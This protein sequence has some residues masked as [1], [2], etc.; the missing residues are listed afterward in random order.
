[1]EKD[2][3]Y[4]PNDIHQPNNVQ[5]NAE[6]FT[7]IQ[8]KIRKAGTD[9]PH[10]VAD[11]YGILWIPLKGTITGYA[12]SYSVVNAIGINERL[13]G[14]WLKFAAWHELTHIFAGHVRSGALP[15]NGYFRQEVDSLAI[16]RHERCAN[17]VSAD[18]C[19]R[20][21]DVFDV[22][23]YNSETMQ[24]YRNMKSY[25]ESLVREFDTI[26]SMYRSEDA[27]PLLKTQIQDLKSKIAG[28]SRSLSDME[29]EINMLNV[30]RTF[31]EM[32]SELGISER[33]FRYKLEAMRIR[34]L[35]IDRQELERYSRMFEGAMRESGT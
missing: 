19:I 24:A 35:D 10:E 31:H 2:T 23:G 17:L 27:S 8:E 13:T 34:G 30:C 20:D 15:D 7:V 28:V 16:P 32:A 1:M 33:I 3:A 9:D 6:I 25:Q 26:R 11:Y 18:V 4:Q 22:S 12:A 29:S 21:D 14:M 5:H